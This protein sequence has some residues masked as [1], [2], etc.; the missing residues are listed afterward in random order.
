MELFLIGLL[1][2]FFKLKT[3]KLSST[4]SSLLYFLNYYDKSKDLLAL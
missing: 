3:D 2:T 1:D 4:S